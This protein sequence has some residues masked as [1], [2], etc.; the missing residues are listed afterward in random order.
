MMLIVV[1]LIVIVIYSSIYFAGS[2]LCSAAQCS[3]AHCACA[4]CAYGRI[5]RIVG[6]GLCSD[7]Q[8]RAHVQHDTHEHGAEN[9]ALIYGCAYLN[10]CKNQCN[11]LCIYIYANTKNDETKNDAMYFITFLHHYKKI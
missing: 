10:Q 3:T 4:F 2:G 1:A 5:L 8:C 9:V 11:V 7:A 6:S